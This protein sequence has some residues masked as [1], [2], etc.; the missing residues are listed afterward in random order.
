MF[1]GG[2][3]ATIRCWRLGSRDVVTCDQGHKEPISALICPEDQQ[4]NT[5]VSAD[6]AGSI[7]LWSIVL[8]ETEPCLVPLVTWYTKHASLTGVLVDAAVCV[9]SVDDVIVYIARTERDICTNGRIEIQMVNS[10]RRA[11]GSHT[12]LLPETQKLP[13]ETGDYEC[14]IFDSSEYS[15]TVRRV[16]Q[17]SY[18]DRTDGEATYLHLLSIEATTPTSAR[19]SKEVDGE[20]KIQHAL[21]DEEG[22]QNR[23]TV[24]TNSSSIPPPNFLYIARSTG[25]VYRFEISP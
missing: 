9:R 14:S 7:F 6:I 16:C 18:E 19:E 22:P 1:S 8:E 20:M 4:G 13:R 10:T 5:L 12:S 21:D 23:V 3:D 24:S 15:L 17:P 11:E 2:N 25:T